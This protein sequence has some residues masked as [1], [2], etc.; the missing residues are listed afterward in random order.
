MSLHT[1]KFEQ[2]LRDGRFTDA[3]IQ[4]KGFLRSKEHGDYDKI[5]LMSVLYCLAQALE[6]Q[7]KI[8][9]AYDTRL[10]VRQLLTAQGS[11]QTSS[12]IAETQ[13]DGF[14]Y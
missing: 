1:D 2:S 14:I 8:G 6:G 4:C 3:E 10:K 12:G 13:S 5:T 9:E 11:L 7:G